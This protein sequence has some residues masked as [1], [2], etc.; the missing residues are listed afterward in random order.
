MLV[1]IMSTP[2]PSAAGRTRPT[3]TT[4]TTRALLAGGVIAGP[5]FTLAWIVEGATRADYNPV[6]HP[7]SS[8]ALGAYGWTQIVTFIVTGLLSMGLA[9]G[10]WRALRPW[11]GSTWGP[12]LVGAYGLGLVGA[13]VF[14][15]DPVSGYPPGTPDQL[16]GYSGLPALLHDVFSIPVFVGLPIACFVFV[17]RFSRWGMRGW[18]TY[19]GL[20]G[21]VFA[22]GFVLASLA[23]GQVADLVAVGGLLQRLTITIGWT[24]LTLLALLLMRERPLRT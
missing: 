2:G 22:V 20:T 3:T 18:A 23:F 8:L 7:V 17:R 15:T 5:V 14:V 9:I 19:A 13:G 16:T 24:W 1:L 12:L 11:G 21:V 10:L 4:G 6:R